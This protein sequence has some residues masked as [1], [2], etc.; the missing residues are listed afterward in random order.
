MKTHGGW[1]LQR[2][3]DGALTWTAPNG[4]TFHVDHTGQYDS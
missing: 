1:H 4:R 2:H 3:V